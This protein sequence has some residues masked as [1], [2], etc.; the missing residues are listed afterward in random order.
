MCN[1]L[2]IVTVGSSPRIWAWFQSTWPKNITATQMQVLLSVLTHPKCFQWAILRK[3]GPGIL[4]K[5]WLEHL[6][7]VNQYLMK[8]HSPMHSIV[9]KIQFWYTPMDACICFTVCS[10]MFSHS[11]TAVL[12]GKCR[13]D[14]GNGGKCA[15]H[16]CWA[17]ENWQASPPWKSEMSNTLGDLI[18]RRV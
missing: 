13:R 4:G 10:T 12:F 18:S 1:T 8:I 9:E 3:G 17:L 14:G 7:D 5:W 16:R 2:P 11:R 15:H 6:I